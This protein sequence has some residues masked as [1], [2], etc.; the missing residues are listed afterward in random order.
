MHGFWT[1]DGGRESLRARGYRS[2]EVKR[3]QS[4]PDITD[5]DLR[6]WQNGPRGSTDRP[7]QTFCKEPTHKALY[8]HASRN[9]FGKSISWFLGELQQV[10]GFSDNSFLPRATLRP[11]ESQQ[12]FGFSDKRLPLHLPV[13]VARARDQAE[14]LGAAAESAVERSIASGGT[15]GGL[16]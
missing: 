15:H 8:D 6:F 2:T 5:R 13:P 11:D 3:C 16:G 4:A 10:F 9:S 14:S 7:I 1:S 12:V